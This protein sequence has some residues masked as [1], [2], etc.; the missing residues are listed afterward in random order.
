MELRLKPHHKNN[1]PLTGILI[2]SASVANWLQQ[3]QHMHLQLHEVIIYPVPGNTANSVWGCLVIPQ[4]TGKIDIGKNEWCQAVTHNIFIPEKAILHPAVTIAELQQLLSENC[5]IFHPEIGLA[6]LAGNLDFAPLLAL[7]QEVHATIRKPADPVFIPGQIKTMQV[8]ALPPEAML[9]KLEKETFPTHEKFKD[10]PLNIWEKVK[11]GF[12]GLLF[13]AGGSGANNTAAGNIQPTGA[14]SKIEHW[15]RKLFGTGDKLFNKMATDFEALE[16]RNQKAL[17]KL[18]DMLRKDP[19]AALK[20]AIPLDEQG[21]SRGSIAGGAE[22]GFTAW[23]NNFSLFGNHGG[24]GRTGQSIDLGDGFYKLQQ[25]YNETAKQLIEHGEYQKAAFVYMKLLKNYLLAAQTLEQGKYYQ[26]AATIY[27]KHLQNKNMAA[28]CY[29]SG[30]MTG[31]A[32]EL[33]KELNEYEKV[34]DLYNS[35]KNPAAA[36]PYYEKVIDAYTIKDQ[37]VKASLIYKNKLHDETGGQ[38]L[39]M[40]GW[41]YNKDAENCL[42]HYFDNIPDIKLLK[43]E[44]YNTYAMEVNENNREKFLR[45]I[46]KEYAKQNE[47]ADEIKEMAY[48]I[49]AAQIPVNKEIVTELRGFNPDRELMKDVMRFKL[50]AKRNY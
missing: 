8:V 26:E 16:R 9:E 19:A 18:L 6:E 35:I 43:R 22:I 48:E 25:Q 31:E 13:K 38:E 10:K 39:L 27:L 28:A 15:L 42:S 46:R 23:W 41:Q 3:L 12:Y 14:G 34:G 50:N 29:E 47:L 11:L 49:V 45:V 32:I 44:L 33:Y 30:N 4:I 17:E 37:Y 1:Y 36:K 20:Y 5:H 24:S 7:P 21:T 40:R 2:K